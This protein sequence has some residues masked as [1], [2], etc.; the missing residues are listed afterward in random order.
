MEEIINKL[1]SSKEL[2]NSAYSDLISPG[3]KQAGLALE[4]VLEFANSILLPIKLVNHVTRSLY[5]RRISEYDKRICNLP[6]SEITSVHPDIG[7]PILD[8]FT[9]VTDDELASLFSKLLA[10]A[11]AQSTADTAHP[12]FVSVISQLTPDEARILKHIKQHGVYRIP[13]LIVTVKYD[14]YPRDYV[15]RNSTSIAR[16][17]HID[18][19][20]RLGL[21][22][23]NL[24]NLGL[25]AKN[26]IEGEDREEQ[27]IEL[28]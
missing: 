2:L 21:Y 8:K 5:E 23:D 4:T 14:G 12:S 7:L 6:D 15:C 19:F 17:V 18:N 3:A 9:T 10:S 16:H 27:F 25:I 11:S 13:A 20:K 24:I 26:S 22:F 1:A 28:G